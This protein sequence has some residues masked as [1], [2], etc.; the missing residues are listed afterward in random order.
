MGLLSKL[1]GGPKD[2]D[3]DTTTYIT[4]TLN[5]RLMPID[6]GE[7]FEDPLDA[8]LEKNGYGAA[9]GGGTMQNEDGTIAYC[10]VEIALPDISDD[11]L[12]AIAAELTRLG[13]PR[14]SKLVG[15]DGETILEFGEKEILSL[16]LDGVG[17][18]PGTYEEF[19]TDTFVGQIEKILG[20]S[21][22]L[23]GGR[24]LNERTEFYFSGDSFLEMKFRL[25]SEL[26]KF[27]I[28]QNA[29]M[30]QIV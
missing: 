17:L 13:A 4:A 20:D 22:K 6:R 11:I 1:F 5:C 2:Q 26:G 29:I 19:D 10:D 9:S 18:P 30:E 21:G 16:S 14:G 28:C 24:A 7:L 25:N 12:G 3:V 23:Q 15:D 8:F 27:P